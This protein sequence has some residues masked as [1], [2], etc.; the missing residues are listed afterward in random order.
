[1]IVMIT[2]TTALITV[3]AVAHRKTVLSV[4]AM[5]AMSV[6]ATIEA[7]AA[8]TMTAAIAAIRAVRQVGGVIRAAGMTQ[9]IEAKVQTAP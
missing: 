9:A 1:M 7:V 8:Q 3:H 6:L 4:A 2:A 5:I